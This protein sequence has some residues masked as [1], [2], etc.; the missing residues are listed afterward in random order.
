METLINQDAFKEIFKQEVHDFLQ[1]IS[2]YHGQQNSRKKPVR[3]CSTAR[4]L[5]GSGH[6]FLMNT[7]KLMNRKVA[8]CLIQ[9]K[10]QTVRQPLF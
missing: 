9:E 4:V 2:L 1:K 8:G 10:R 7:L 3:I 5:S 6:L